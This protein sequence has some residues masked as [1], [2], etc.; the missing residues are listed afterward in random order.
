MAASP[1]SEM[2][3]R[4]KWCYSNPQLSVRRPHAD[5]QIDFYSFPNYLPTLIRGLV[6]K[7]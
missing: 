6:W 7:K 3:K 2:Q 4:K 5:L 1:L